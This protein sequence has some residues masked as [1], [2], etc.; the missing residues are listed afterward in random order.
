MN[1]KKI[2]SLIILLVII[3]IMTTGCITCKASCENTIVQ[4]RIIGIVERT[5]LFYDTHIVVLTSGEELYFIKEGSRS[6]HI[7]VKDWNELNNIT[8]GGQYQW[9]LEK[10]TSCSIEKPW[11]LK[12]LS[13]I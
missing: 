4:K 11:T 8:A 2:V 10:D 3:A 1:N 12:S 13:N 7:L 6:H 5:Y 9:I